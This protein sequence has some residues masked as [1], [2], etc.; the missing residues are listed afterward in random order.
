MQVFLR[1]SPGTILQNDPRRTDARGYLIDEWINQPPSGGT[2]R[3][4]MGMRTDEGRAQS[5]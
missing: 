1:L 5:R 4:M 3:C 2:D